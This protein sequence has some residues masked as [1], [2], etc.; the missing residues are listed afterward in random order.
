MYVL[1]TAWI[2]ATVISSD[3]DMC[4]VGCLSHST[5]VLQDPEQLTL[6]DHMAQVGYRKQLSCDVTGQC[7]R[8]SKHFAF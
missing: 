1:I 8:E 7:S 6:M 4:K 3:F 5:I 2:V